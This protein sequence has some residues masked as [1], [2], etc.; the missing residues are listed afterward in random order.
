MLKIK[1]KLIIIC[2]LL[3]SIN[4]LPVVSV[5]SFS[6]KKTTS[7]ITSPQQ[8]FPV[9][10]IPIS[11]GFTNPVGIDYHPLFNKVIISANYPSGQP[12]NFELI[13]SDGT[14][15]PF[16]TVKGLTDELKIAVAQNDSNGISMGG[17]EAGT[18][19]SGTG[20]PGHILKIAAN[21]NS[22]QNPWVVL[23]GEAGLLRGGLHVDRTGV[24]G[25]DL[26]VVTT[27]GGVWRI[28]SAGQATKLAS[29]GVHLEGVCTIPNDVN[30][31]GPWA[32]K[33]LAGAEQQSRFHTVDAQGKVESYSFLVPG[34]NSFIQPEDI[35]LI[36]SNENFFGIHQGEGKIVGAPGSAFSNMVGDIAVA[37]EFPG[38]LYR[39]HWN[40]L[41]FEVTTIAQ[42]SAFEHVTF[43]KSGIVEVPSSIGNIEF[44][45]N[46]Y[47]VSENIATANVSV[48]RTGGT[49][50]YS[51]VDFTTLETAAISPIHF[52][53]TSGRLIFAPGETTKTFPITIVNNNI[54]DC[55][56]SITLK[57]SNPTESVLGTVT[58]A[59]LSITDDD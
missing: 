12:H 2:L 10:L 34:A 1:V 55:D 15:S 46:A 31:Y 39:F 14:H 33:I 28:S 5:N 43:S 4:F 27:V 8:S 13:A 29:I 51:T 40:K 26:I 23:P 56:K 37:Q 54:K 17:F 6:P 36:P 20:T 3:V 24:F 22:F 53:A 11:T 25:G 21:G 35:D 41:Y 44:T 32:G 50:A 38:S 47:Q 49:N 9:R 57:L 42:V 52:I 30:K 18:V 59:V 16:S 45:T 58:S 19:F 7:P 48:K